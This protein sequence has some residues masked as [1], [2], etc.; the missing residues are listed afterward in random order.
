MKVL[1]LFLLVNFVIGLRSA[2]TDAALKRLPLTGLCIA[3]A[4]LLSRYRWV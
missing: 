1:A 2:K 3:T 4:F